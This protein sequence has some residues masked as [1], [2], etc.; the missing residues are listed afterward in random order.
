MWAAEQ[1]HP[2]A[3]K[4]LLAAR[5]RSAARS[6]AARACRATTWRRA[7]NQRAVEHAQDRRD[8]AAAAGSTYEEQLTIDQKSGVEVGGQRGLGQALGRDGNPLPRPVG[9]AVQAQP[10]SHAPAGAGARAAPPAAPARR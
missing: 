8:A 1:K 10:R 7:S 3:V 9:R 2:E 6:R 5:R 4:V